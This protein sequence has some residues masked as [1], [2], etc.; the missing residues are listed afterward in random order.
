[1]LA[2]QLL[3]AGDVSGVTRKTVLYQGVPVSGD[4]GRYLSSERIFYRVL[5]EALHRY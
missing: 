4:E 2:G 3:R 5:Y 1:M